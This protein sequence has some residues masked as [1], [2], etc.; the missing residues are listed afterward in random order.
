MGF[1][2]FADAYGEG[3]WQEFSKLA[4]TRGIKVVAN[5]R[6]QRT[7]TSVT[8]QVLKLISAPSPMRC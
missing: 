3:W 7:D 5:E 8:G 4:E 1:I 2:G 6:Y